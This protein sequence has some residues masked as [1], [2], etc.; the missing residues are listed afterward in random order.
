MKEVILPGQKTRVGCDTC[1][2]I[3]SATFRYD[4][5]TLDD[6]LKVPDA[7]LAFCDVCGSRVA[8]AQQSAHLVRRAHHIKRKKTSLRLPRV[9]SDLAS[10]LVSDAG[11]DPSQTAAPELV[12]KAMLATLLDHPERRELW[13]QRMTELRSD[14]ILAQPSEKKINLGLTPRLLEELAT[15]QEV[16]HLTQSQVI[17]MTLLAAR[18]DLEV[19]KELKKLVALTS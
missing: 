19:G 9:L 11:G 7:M 12:L 1:K 18:A 6:G 4:T 17:R 5:L 3:Q 15:L 13:A 16:S 14:P 2:A 8:M 10:L